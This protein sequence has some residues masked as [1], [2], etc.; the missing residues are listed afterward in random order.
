MDDKLFKENEIASTKAPPEKLTSEELIKFAGDTMNQLNS[1]LTPLY[2]TMIAGLAENKD[3]ANLFDGF[4]FGTKE[5]IVKSA[6]KEFNS[7][8]TSERKD[9][10]F[11]LDPVAVMI[12]E[13]WNKAAGIATI[14]K[15]TLITAHGTMNSAETLIGN[16]LERYLAEQI[17]ESGWFWSAGKSVK[18]TDFIKYQ[19]GKL[20]L[21]QVKNSEDSENWASGQVRLGTEIVPWFRR[22]SGKNLGEVNWGEFPD[23]SVRHK[24]SE[25][26]F[27][28]YVEKNI[29]HHI[30][31]KDNSGL[32]AGLSDFFSKVIPKNTKNRGVA[33]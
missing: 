28:E 32:L 18:H 23:E 6:T 8:K 30:P 21:L 16:L 12:T 7:R 13:K 25:S 29:F 9:P 10:N 1:K 2:L 4:E 27:H 24:I 17:E 19:D 31:V 3:C 26:G 15:T 5:W 11:V 22:K 20:S 14:D 33:D